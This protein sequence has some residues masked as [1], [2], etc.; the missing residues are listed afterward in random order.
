MEIVFWII[1]LGVAWFIISSVIMGFKLT[2]VV[3]KILEEIYTLED[4]IYSPDQLKPF[5][6]NSNRNVLEHDGFHDISWENP[7]IE[8]FC[9]DCIPKE[10]YLRVRGANEKYIT[11]T[12]SASYPEDK[13]TRA[14]LMYNVEPLI[15]YPVSKEAMS[16]GMKFRIRGAIDSSSGKMYK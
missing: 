5:L 13:G 8:G 2:K 12:L 14:K 10:R 9:F 16:L 1:G 3:E 6:E 15:N 7:S 11:F 4:Y